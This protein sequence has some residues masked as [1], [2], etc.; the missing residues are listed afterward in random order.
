ML[1]LG[2]PVPRCGGAVA[3]ALL[4]H[5]RASPSGQGLW[6]DKDFPASEMF[7]SG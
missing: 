4:G 3:D 2:V 7:P 6:F 5:H 1:W